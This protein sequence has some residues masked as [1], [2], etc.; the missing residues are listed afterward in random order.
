MK[1][2]K[3]F[4]KTKIRACISI[5]A[6]GFAI[7]F[8]GLLYGAMM[9]GVPTQ[10]PPPLVHSQEAFDTLISDGM[11]TGGAMIFVIGLTALIFLSV[12]KIFRK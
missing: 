11:M 2:I 10:D 4:F 12:V 3:F 9:V 5:A 8:I 7:A 1:Y 6:F